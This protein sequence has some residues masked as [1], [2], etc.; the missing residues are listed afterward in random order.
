MPAP[1]RAMEMRR[2][3][4]GR[5]AVWRSL[6]LW[7][8]LTLGLPMF[9]FGLTGSV[10]VFWQEIDAGLN[11]ALFEVRQ[12]GTRISLDAAIHA[13]SQAAPPGWDSIWLPVPASSSSAWPFHFYYPDPRSGEV[14]AESLNVFIDPG[15]GSV[16]GQRVFYHPWNPFGHSFVGFFFKL[17]YA[18]FLGA[19]GMLVVGVIGVLLLASTAS[20]V[21]IWWPRG[22]KWRSALSIK[23]RASRVRLTHDLHQ[24]AAI[25]PLLVLLAV[26][27]SGLSFNLPDQ[28]SW[29]VERF[30][31]ISAAPEPPPEPDARK[32]P[33][34]A[35][36]PDAAA[37][38]DAALADAQRRYPGG[39]LESITLSSGDDTVNACY[40]DVPSLARYVQDT[41]CF[42]IAGATGELLGVQDASL[43]TGG[44]VFMTWQWP[45][46]S[47][48][49]LGWTGRILVFLTGI[50]CAVLPVTGLLRWMQK[51][52][53]RSDAGQRIRRAA[54]EA[55]EPRGP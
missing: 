7:L 41:R 1:A 2:S 51:R 9:V 10:L 48:T 23:R 4:K 33:A 42:V 12:T 44:D 30:S 34:G 8:G 3:R 6:H 52:R 37:P 46:H 28:F 27:V 40:A 54:G 19:A 13:A 43:G 16:I 45:L 50:A 39:R 31:T 29:V 47:G 15:T 32:S 11:P 25:Y 20:G 17:H 22:G 35:A 24:V 38:L 26:L 21:V 5:R 55:L 36:A 53:A 49:I 18:F 14:G